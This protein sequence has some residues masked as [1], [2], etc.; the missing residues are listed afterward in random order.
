MAG[1]KKGRKVLGLNSGD[2]V[3][4]DDVEFELLPRDRRRGRKT[5]VAITAPTHKQI[6]HIPRKKGSAVVKKLTTSQ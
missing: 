6:K 4:V 2:T 5:S 3:V 1:K